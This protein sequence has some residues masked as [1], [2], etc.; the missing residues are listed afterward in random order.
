MPHTNPNSF[1]IFFKL[2][3]EIWCLTLMFTYFIELQYLLESFY[4]IDVAVFIA[5]PPDLYRNEHGTDT[6]F[7]IINN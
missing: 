3:F 6:I 1:Y 2:D 5:I 7:I 4:I